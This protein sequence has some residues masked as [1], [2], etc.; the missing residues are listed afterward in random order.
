[1]PSIG[2]SATGRSVARSRRVKATAI[3]DGESLS[4]ETGGCTR[5]RRRPTTPAGQR[6]RRGS[7]A[8]SRTPPSRR[9]AGGGRRCRCA[10]RASGRLRRRTSPAAPCRHAARRSRRMSRRPASADPP[11]RSSPRAVSVR[12]A[13]R[14]LTGVSDVRCLIPVKRFTLAKRRLAGL[15]DDDQRVALA[16][17]LAGRVVAAAGTLPVF[18]ACEDEA[19]AAWADTVGAAGAVD[20]RTRTQRRRRVEQDD[21]LRQGL[22]PSGDRPQRSAAGGRPRRRWPSSGRS[23]LVPDRR[24]SGHQR[25]RPARRGARSPSATALGRSTPT[26]PRRWRS[27]ASRP[28]G[29][30]VEVRRDPRLALD[31]DTPDDLAHPALR[32]ELPGWLR[33]IL[34]S[35]R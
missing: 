5:R 29:L 21:D 22:R 17:W 27:P 33:T 18:V 35:R 6:R 4:I 9:R 3:G 7:A 34:A 26:C 8:W 13:P 12:V 19:V 25:A 10:G 31:V 1:M 20:A 28:P 11:R 14:I 24:G 32:T 30:R 16:Q 15:L 23:R 2:M